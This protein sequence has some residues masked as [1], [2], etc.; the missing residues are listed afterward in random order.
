[1]KKWLPIFIFFAITLKGVIHFN[2]FNEIQQT[3]KQTKK[4]DSFVMTKGQKGSFEYEGDFQGTEE[5]LMQVLQSA[6]GDRFSM[7]SKLENEK[8]IVLMNPKLP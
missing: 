1:M 7:E 3:L 5:E 8:L 2:D 6:A 4:V